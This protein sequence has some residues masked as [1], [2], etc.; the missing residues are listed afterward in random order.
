MPGIRFFWDGDGK[1]IRL[2]GVLPARSEAASG[3]MPMR[4]LWYVLDPTMRIMTVVP[5]PLAE[6]HRST[7]VGRSGL[8]WFPLTEG[9]R[10][11][12]AMFCCRPARLREVFVRF[13]ST[14]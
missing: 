7:A 10:N 1:I 3:A 14:I 11:G 2:Y 13:R 6:E 4:P 9:L 12:P 8:G 5:D